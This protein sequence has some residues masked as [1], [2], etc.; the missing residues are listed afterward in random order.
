MNSLTWTRERGLT[1][2]RGE[3]AR[4]RER[5]SVGDRRSDRDG[6]GAAAVVAVA[7]AASPVVALPRLVTHSAVTESDGW[8]RTERTGRRRVWSRRGL[9]AGGTAG[10]GIMTSIIINTALIRIDFSKCSRKKKQ[11]KQNPAAPNSTDNKTTEL[12]LFNSVLYRPEGAIYPFHAQISVTSS[13]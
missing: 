8:R 2:S 7:V 13:L 6:G 3:R 12:F 10:G 5:E 1:A 4:D 11:K 9:E